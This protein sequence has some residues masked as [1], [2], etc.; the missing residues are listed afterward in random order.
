VWNVEDER[1]LFDFLVPDPSAYSFGRRRPSVLYVT[2]SP[3]GRYFYS[4]VSQF[5]IRRRFGGAFDWGYEQVGYYWD[6]HRGGQVTNG[7]TQSSISNAIEAEWKRVKISFDRSAYLLAVSKNGRLAAASA[8]VRDWDKF[9]P[10]SEEGIQAQT[11]NVYNNTAGGAQKG[12]YKI[13]TGTVRD[14]RF[15]QDDTQLLVDTSDT[16]T[17]VFDIAST[18][19]VDTIDRFYLERQFTMLPQAISSVGWSADGKKLAVAKY[20]QRFSDNGVSV[21]DM[22]KAS[23]INTFAT[24]LRTP[25]EEKVLEDYQRNMIA[26]VTFSPDGNDVTLGMLP[27][28]FRTYNAVSGRP[29]AYFETGYEPYDRS[30]PPVIKA[31]YSPD[32]RSL[33]VIT[34]HIGESTKTDV[35]RFVYYPEINFQGI[36][37][38]AGNREL[39]ASAQP[40]ISGISILD[41]STGRKTVELVDYNR[42]KNAAGDDME[43]FRN[44]VFSPD[45]RFVAAA[46]IRNLRIWDSASGREIRTFKISDGY[47]NGS[48]EIQWAYSE[49][50]FI[51]VH[52]DGRRVYEDEMEYKY[53][54]S[55]MPVPKTAGST[56]AYSP[57]GSLLAVG[58]HGK[59]MLFDM[60]ANRELRQFDTAILPTAAVAISADNKQVMAMDQVGTLIVW[61]AETGREIK[62]MTT[63][64]AEGLNPSSAVFSPD[65]TRIAFITSA[66]N[67]EVWHIPSGEGAALAIF[68]PEQWTAVATGGGSWNASQLGRRY[69]GY[70]NN[71]GATETVSELSGNPELLQAILTGKTDD[72]ILARLIAVREE[73]R[74][75]AQAAQQSA[76]AAAQAQAAAVPPQAGTYSRRLTAQKERSTRPM[77]LHKVVVG[78]TNIQVFVSSEPDKAG[79]SVPEEWLA[80]KRGELRSLVNPD[81][82]YNTNS[83]SQQIDLT[84]ATQIDFSVPENNN[85]FYVFSFNTRG[86]SGRRFSFSTN[87][88]V[89]PEID[90][91]QPD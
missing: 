63:N 69:A 31:A 29:V 4:S 44:A 13:P 5:F 89:F 80:N 86:I 43:Q 56:L 34:G 52:P 22:E 91:E 85:W 11:V 59:V 9:N 75:A 68:T 66:Y 17:Y 30:N 21:W 32:N 48:T 14:I 70:I 39:K 40:F 7:R 35:K 50:G 73:E 58:G 26:S 15:S 49:E 45:G 16:K 33:L 88:Y 23:L 90:L 25:A 53:Y 36:H 78:R 60:R 2:W 8:K 87:G 19:I 71:D 67:V 65:S 84:G 82:V 6:A 54:G 76:A 18:E 38:A 42:E 72:G 37:Q 3:D 55:V 79:S 28:F 62:R 74:A 77:Y 57:D 47:V 12:T 1:L 64:R 83:A 61:D 81:Q 10:D 51:R 41:K 46:G 27:K 20:N 24:R